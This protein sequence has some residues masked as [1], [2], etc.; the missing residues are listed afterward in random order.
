MNLNACSLQRS[1]VE[2]AHLSIHDDLTSLHNRRHF[3]EYLDAALERARDQGDSLG[4]LLFDLNDFKEIN[5]S[6]GHGTGDLMLATL[7]ER[8]RDTL[9]DSDLAARCAVSVA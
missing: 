1:N 9:R 8:V 6:Y 5:D 7:G 3:D 2:L 4:L